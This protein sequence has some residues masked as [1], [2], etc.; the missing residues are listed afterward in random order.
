MNVLISLTLLLS[1]LCINSVEAI[2]QPK[3]GTTW[4]IVLGHKI[5]M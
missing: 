1:L 4:N 5:D 2:W 3:P